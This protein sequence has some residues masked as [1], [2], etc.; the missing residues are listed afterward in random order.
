MTESAWKELVEQGFPADKD[1]E[2]NTVWRPDDVTREQM[3]R[4]ET[5]SHPAMVEER[6]RAKQAKLDIS[7]QK[8][9][10]GVT[11]LTKVA[12]GCAAANTALVKVMQA[13]L[14]AS[15]PSPDV[16]QA[17]VEDLHALSG[18]HLKN[19]I[20]GRMF[21]GSKD[22]DY[23]WPTTKPRSID[24]ARASVNG[25]AAPTLVSEAYRVRAD[26]VVLDRPAPVSTGPVPIPAPPRRLPIS[27]VS[28]TP[29]GNIDVSRAAAASEMLA[30]PAWVALV[31]STLLVSKAADHHVANPD[32]AD[33]VVAILTSRLATHLDHRLAKKP[34]AREQ[35]AWSFAGHNLSRVVA[36]LE[37]HGLFIRSP[38]S[39]QHD[40]TLLRPADSASTHI[41]V[42]E[43]PSA[44]G[45][46]M[47]YNM[48]WGTWVRAGKV[49]S[50]Q[51]QR[52]VKA[53]C[54]EHKKGSE[55]KSGASQDSRFYTTY[56]ATPAASGGDS[57]SDL[58][59]LLGPCWD[60]TH[61]ASKAALCDETDN[62]LL[63]WPEM[64]LKPLH[65][66]KT[67]KD[68]LFKKLSM[69][70]YLFELVLDLCISST[71]NVSDAPG[72]ESMTGVH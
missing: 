1:P 15:A 46:Y 41:T 50:A 2:G 26:P 34:S 28:V 12:D 40:V 27:T 53:R 65:N 70:G 5:L 60:P 61:S 8:A 68:M 69:A 66:N 23:A 67:S 3:R 37:M 10:A 25:Q 47:Y 48:K 7:A 24:D 22:R 72:F 71:D 42:D 17:E 16:T 21:N 30:N 54:D 55:L 14:G 13:R 58:V 51:A 20:Y 63:V 38:V 4:V 6:R 52:G 62:G 36:L 18:T 9:A 19:F 29:F 49:V 31:R 57:F 35:W 43:N 59:A 64:V 44:Q 32:R 11:A 56:P 45:C 39:A 33:A